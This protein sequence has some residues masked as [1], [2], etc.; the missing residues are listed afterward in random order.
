M[1]SKAKCRKRFPNAMAATPVKK[2]ERFAS[3]ESRQTTIFI[4][5]FGMLKIMMIF[6][7]LNP[8]SIQNLL[9]NS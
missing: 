1:P 8:I 7:A 6:A 5:R 2:T 3:A 9:K 4:E